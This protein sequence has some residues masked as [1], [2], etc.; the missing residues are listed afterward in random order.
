MSSTAVLGAIFGD[1]AKAKIVDVLSKD[2]DVVVRFQGGSN[3]GHT[4]K[5]DNEKYVFHLVPS[6]ILYPNVKCCIGTSV[7]VDLKSLYT[8]ITE[9]E[10]KGINFANRFFIDT[11]ANIVLPIH[12]FLD[13]K[14]E[15]SSNQTKIGTTK[16]GIGPC[17][18]DAAARVGIKLSDFNYPDYL[19]ERIKN[20]YLY[21]HYDLTD[22]QKTIDEQMYYAEKLIEYQSDLPYLLNKFY[23]EGKKIIFEGAQGSLLDINFG[24][25][26]FVTSSSTISGGIS[27]Q[28]GFP[29]HKIDKLIGVYKSYFTR[30]GKGPFPTEL[31]D[32]T[33]DF[34][35]KAG[36]EFGSTTGR[37]RR[38]G[39]FDAVAAKYTA[40]INGFDEIAL[41]LLDVLSGLEKIKI[42]T[43]YKIRG[44]ELDFFP[45]SS[46]QLDVVFPKYLE[47]EGWKEDISHITEYRDLPKNAKIYVETIEKILDKK[48]S[49]ISVGA[50][51]NQTIFR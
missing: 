48:V 14:S 13:S 3:A 27:S 39:W 42:C 28:T 32:E 29:P 23:S 19:K 44:Y 7:C 46:Y 43:A 5:K 26:P 37:P 34:I 25:Y 18:S 35:R 30:V 12:K 36:N 16:R 51:R 47:L 50:D 11:R 2:A 9:L 24:T 22:L 6:G 49:V 20:L 21:H 31:K 4:I 8:E 33:G 40:I 41:T 38:V 15:N 10:S 1:E 45:A 17:Y